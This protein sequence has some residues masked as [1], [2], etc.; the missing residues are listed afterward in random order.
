MRAAA[1]LLDEGA[2]Y[3]HFGA[4][5]RVRGRRAVIRLVYRPEESRTHAWWTRIELAL[6]PGA[7]LAEGLVREPDFDARVVAAVDVDDGA[8]P[9][10]T[11]NGVVARAHLAGAPLLV[12]QE[13]GMLEGA[14]LER[15]LARS[16]E[17]ARL[18][19]G[20]EGK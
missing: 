13:A 14:D 18:D 20:E 3:S 8:D 10:G 5:G 7:P 4:V 17:L 2:T 12:V 15:L 19:R 11:T 16:L 9:A 6:A 1:R